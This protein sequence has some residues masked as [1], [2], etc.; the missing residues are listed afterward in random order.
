V[1]VP[2]QPSFLQRAAESID[3]QP[4][5]VSFWSRLV[6]HRHCVGCVSS[7]LAH[8]Q[9]VKFSTCFSTLESPEAVYDTP[10]GDNIEDF[11]LRQDFSHI[12]P[13]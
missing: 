10:P 7:E 4:Q 8:K 11:P 9:N 12:V 1:I 13:V 3:L 5:G 6:V 2:K